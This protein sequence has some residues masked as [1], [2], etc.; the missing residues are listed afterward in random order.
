MDDCTAMETDS[1]GS[2]T[3]VAIVSLYNSWSS[4]SEQ[5]SRFVDE[6]DSLDDHDRF[7]S[8]PWFDSMNTEDLLRQLRKRC[9]EEDIHHLPR[10]R[11]RKKPVCR[12]VNH[13]ATCGTTRNRGEPLSETTT[14]DLLVSNQ[15]MGLGLYEKDA[16]FPLCSSK[17][18]HCDEY[19]LK[20]SKIEGEEEA[21]KAGAC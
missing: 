3:S 14:E 17:A 6:D 11:R 9:R 2:E 21:P 1:I 20:K 8:L 10:L 18:K 4:T 12:F 7:A 15:D 16:L 19:D 13:L 5:E